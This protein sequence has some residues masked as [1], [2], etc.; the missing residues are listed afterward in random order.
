LVV[1]IDTENVI[2]KTQHVF[3]IK[4]PVTVGPRTIYLNRIKAVYAKPIAS[5]ILNGEHLKAIPLKPGMR[6]SW[7]L[8]PPL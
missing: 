6:Q 5:I 2:D 7:S 4:V 8:S 1:S 3:M